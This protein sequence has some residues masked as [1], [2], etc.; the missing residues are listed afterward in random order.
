MHAL[1]HLSIRTKLSAGFALALALNVTVGLFALF[2]LQ[3]LSDFATDV[4]ESW[5]PEVENLGLIK[6]A[7]TEHRLLAERRLETRDVRQ[8]ASIAENMDRAAE[9]VAEGARTFAEKADEDEEHTLMRGFLAQWTLY[10]ESL[11]SML[12]RLESGDEEAAQANLRAGPLSVFQSTE[13]RIDALLDVVNEEGIEAAEEGHQTYWRFFALTVAL[14][15]LAAICLGGAVAWVT[16]N[17]STPIRQISDAMRRLTAGDRSVGIDTSRER[18][19]EIGDLITAAAGYRDSLVETQRLAEEATLERERLDAAINNMPIGVSM[20]DASKR[21]IICNRTYIDMYSVPTELTVPG[22]DLLPMLRQRVKAGVYSGDDPERYIK[23]LVEKVDRHEP[24]IDLIELRDGRVLSLTYQ[25]MPSGGWV[26]LHEDVTARRKIEAR[27]AHMARHDALTDLPNRILF[28]ERVEAALEARKDEEKVAILCLDLDQFKAVN[29]TLGH[30]I[31]DELLCNVAARLRNAVRESD[32]VARLGGDEF[33]I[34]QVGEDQPLG[35]TA[36]AE[37]IIEN[38][39]VPYEIG[40]H[41]V[42][43]G[44]SIGIAVAPSDGTDADVLLKDADMALYRAKH[45]G[46]GTY[47]FFEPEMDAR[48]QARRLLELDLRRALAMKEF[49]VHYQPLLDLRSNEISGFEALL[50][51]AHPERG[52]VSP[53][54]FIPIAEEIGLIV[55]I[56]AWVLRQACMDAVRWP[57][58]ITVA[59][60]L[61]PVQ[62]KDKK[63][64]QTVI[65]A[66][67]VSKLPANRLELEITESVLLNESESTLATMNQLHALGVR[68]AMDDFGTGYSSLS[69]LRS[70]PFDK[71]KID[72]SFIQDASE[73]GTSIAIIRAVTG[74][75]TSLGIGS[76]AEG[77]ETAEQL[78]RARQEGCTEV[79]G[80]FV[81]KPRPASEI[82]EFLMAREGL[83][84]DAA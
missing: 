78:M 34:V 27:I 43:S 54:E 59:V 58:H 33:A 36:L 74:I 4:T 69:Y 71:I 9:A 66:L 46:R 7:M 84:I 52:I 62:F 68:I 23:N 8:I 79:Q 5:L 26:S 75:G 24:Y 28:H 32:A 14:I 1:G 48:M 16:R 25:P 35:A 44:T 41:E 67:A 57:D 61:S 81:S 45:D 73:K 13:A 21:L 22:T 83:A 40:G 72:R 30:P 2:Q 76:T 29:D 19:D 31:G 70:F 42:I 39:N 53:G 55:P 6:H 49:V 11:D 18:H 51:W 50:R 80:Y 10:R 15:L 63:L 17:I 37:R 64:L 65:T 60:N 20:F 47:R 77:V 82:G 38:L 12:D 3:T 56:G